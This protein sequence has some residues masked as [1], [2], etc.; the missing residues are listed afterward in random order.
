M[1][2]VGIGN[3][4]FRSCSSLTSVTIPGSVTSIGRSAF[5]SCSSLTSVTI[6]E[7]MTNIRHHAFSGCTGLT[8]ITIPNSVISIG[9]EAFSGCS[10]LSSIIVESGN[11]VYD[12]RNNCNAIIETATNEL[13]FGCQNTIIPNSVTSIGGGAFE[14]C[15]GLTSITIPNSVTSIGSR[16]FFDCTNLTD[17]YCYAQNPPSA[18]AYEVHYDAELV[19]YV[20]P[21]FDESIILSATLHVPASSVET[22]S[23]TIPWSEFGSIVAIE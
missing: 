11:S 21:T 18:H 12:S 4:A 15:S 5:E 3:D 7:G 16:A 9:S 17:V 1:N 14:Y 13:I 20:F 22:Y 6:P 10:S 23:T 8:S 2:V 19:Y